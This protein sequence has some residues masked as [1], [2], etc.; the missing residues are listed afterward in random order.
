MYPVAVFLAASHQ[1]YFWQHRRSGG[2]VF[3]KNLSQIYNK[4]GRF[5]LWGG[6]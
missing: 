2:N 5:R 1:R 4:I 6:V 3:L